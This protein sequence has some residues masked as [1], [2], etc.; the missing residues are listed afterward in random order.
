[1]AIPIPPNLPINPVVDFHRND[2]ISPPTAPTVVESLGAIDPRVA[3]NLPL[4]V[5]DSSAGGSLQDSLHSAVSRGQSS[6]LLPTSLDK[7]HQSRRT[8]S[9]PLI[10]FLIFSSLVPKF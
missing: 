2:L 1:M 8:I 3:L 7:I 4:P 5:A 6:T 9:R 10:S